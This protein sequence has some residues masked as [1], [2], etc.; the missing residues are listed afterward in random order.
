[1]FIA[2]VTLPLSERYSPASFK[3]RS[4]SSMF[5]ALR[6]MLITYVLMQSGLTSSRH[7]L[8][9]RNVRSSSS[10]SGESGSQSGTSGRGFFIS[11]VSHSNFLSSV[12]PP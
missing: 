1:M 10:V 3:N 9:V 4:T 2:L 11:R 6:V 8:I 5:A 12:M 7:S